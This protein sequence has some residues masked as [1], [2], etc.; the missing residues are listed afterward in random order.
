MK[1]FACSLIVHVS[2]RSVPV[3]GR[4]HLQTVASLRTRQHGA[5]A[6]AY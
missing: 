5:G 4:V 6:A 1:Q 3:S 2:P